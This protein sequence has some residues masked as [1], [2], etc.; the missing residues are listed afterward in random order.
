MDSTSSRGEIDGDDA[1]DLLTSFEALSEAKDFDVFPLRAVVL[2]LLVL[3]FLLSY[4][5]EQ[6]CFPFRCAG[7][8][9]VS[10]IGLVG[11]EKHARAAS[12]HFSASRLDFESEV[13]IHYIH[14]A[15]VAMAILN[16][17]VLAH[18]VLVTALASNGCCE[19]WGCL[20]ENR[21]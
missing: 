14:A 11:F 10:I 12:D 7:C 2:V 8:V 16:C 20:I 13:M 17:T 4:C 3:L 6:R 5:N 15:F 19:S 1:F 18:G 9:G 21:R